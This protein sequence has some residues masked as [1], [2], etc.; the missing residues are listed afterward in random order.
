MVSVGLINIRQL[1]AAKAV[2]HPCLK[3]PDWGSIGGY[4]LPIL[5]GFLE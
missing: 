2:I 3:D 5:A 1:P 4:Q